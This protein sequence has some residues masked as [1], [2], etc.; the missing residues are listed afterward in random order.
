MRKI[1]LELPGK[2]RQDAPELADE[3][4]I[5]VTRP[6]GLA[7][8]DDEARLMLVECLRKGPRRRRRPGVSEQ[9]QLEARG[10]MRL[11]E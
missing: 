7:C 10:Q 3:Y 9:Q 2:R 6:D 4:T 11:M 8:T 1:F 5:T